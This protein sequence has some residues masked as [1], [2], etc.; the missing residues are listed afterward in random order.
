MYIHIYIYIYIYVSGKS[1]FKK[2]GNKVVAKAKAGHHTVVVK[3]EPGVCLT[4]C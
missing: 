4:L 3:K 2:V 1:S